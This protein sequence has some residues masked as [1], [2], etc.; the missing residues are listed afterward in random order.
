MRAMSGCCWWTV[1][2]S[3]DDEDRGLGHSFRGEY[4]EAFAG[5]GTSETAACGPLKYHHRCRWM[6]GVAGVAN[7]VQLLVF[8]LAV[9]IENHQLEW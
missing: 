2:C 4:V 8:V 6:A 9:Q 3:K 5:S 7:V 1:C